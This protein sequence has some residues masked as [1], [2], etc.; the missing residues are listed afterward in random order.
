MTKN[1][2]MAG[3]LGMGALIFAA[4]FF[5]RDDF[6]VATATVDSPILAEDQP[7]AIT[8]DEE[9]VFQR[10]FWRRPSPQDRILHAEHRE[11]TDDR[12]LKKW[13]WF[14]KVQGSP[15][16][17]KFLRE[18]NPFGMICGPSRPVIKD[19][20]SWFTPDD[21]NSDTLR[22]KQGELMMSF[23]RTDRMIFATDRGYGFRAGAPE[24]SEVDM[25]RQSGRV[26]A[27]RR[28]PDSL[29]PTNHTQSR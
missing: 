9:A 4:L 27:P 16:L 18:D 28:L 19:P 20:P 13:Q 5:L 17:V 11:W 3:V 14:I 22:S 23:H 15:Q 12:G 2:L 6:K 29:P 10:A 7:T 8:Y 1:F 24:S 26:A 21:P 25:D